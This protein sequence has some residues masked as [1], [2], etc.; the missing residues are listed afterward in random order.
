MQAKNQDSA[1]PRCRSPYLRRR[2]LH[3][4]H[5][6]HC[7]PRPRHGGPSARFVSLAPCILVALAV[8]LALLQQAS[9][10]TSLTLGELF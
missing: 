3:V 10:G 7:D 2:S 8:A 6:N 1:P 9:G 5:G 4:G